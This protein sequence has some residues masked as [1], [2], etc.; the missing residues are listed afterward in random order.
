MGRYRIVG[1][2]GSGGLGVVYKAEDPQLGRAVALKVLPAHLQRDARAKERMM[3]EARAAAALDHPNVCTVYEVAEEPDGRAF[4]ALACYDGHTLRERMQEGPLQIEDA[5]R[6]ARDVAAGLAAAHHRGIVHRDLKPSNVFLCTDGSTKILD[7]GIARVPGVALTTDGSTP[8]TIEYGA[9]ETTRGQV[10]AR[11]DVWSLGVVLYEMLTSR[12]PFDA[13]YEAAVLYAVLNEDP[14]P[15]S[16]VAPSVSPEL[17]AVVARCL[18]KD[19]EARYPDAAA[20]V[21]ALAPEEARQPDDVALSLR[22]AGRGALRRL[23]HSRVWQGGLAAAL[24]GLVA[25]AVMVVRPPDAHA[26]PEAIRLAILPLE[27]RPDAPEDSAFAIGL[28]DELASGLV[29]ARGDANL[30]VIPLSEINEGRIQTAR[31]AS[32]ELGANLVVEG[33]ILREND[34]M[35][36]VLQLI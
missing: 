3:V 35:R 13:P 12:R 18:E 9:P 22:R 11:S 5:V 14:A 26:L 21:Q 23:R 29:Q 2:L 7:F 19:P 28:A 27:P 10:D 8:G 30:S 1:E 20:L 31:E 32:L 16:S 24:V 36:V 25:V 17:D 4:I 33:R 15:A 6:I 34:Q